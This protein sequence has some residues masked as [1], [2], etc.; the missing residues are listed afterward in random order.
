[1]PPNGLLGY[2]WRSPDGQFEGAALP[3]V[4]VSMCARQSRRCFRY[5]YGT[6]ADGRR[7]CLLRRSKSWP[8]LGAVARAEGACS[9]SV[10]ALVCLPLSIPGRRALDIT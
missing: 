3:G 4:V 10:D 5:L 2:W 6:C 7:S 9:D 1:M 8:L